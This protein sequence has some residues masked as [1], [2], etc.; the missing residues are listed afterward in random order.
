MAVRYEI[1]HTGHKLS[2]LTQTTSLEFASVITNPT[3]TGLVVLN[4]SPLFITPNIGVAT[5]SA[6][7]NLLKSGGTLTGNL[8]FT[9]NT[10]DIGASGATRPRTGYFGTSLIVPTVIGS[11]TTAGNLI[12]RGNSADLTTGQVNITSSLEASSISVAALTTA[13]GLAVAKRLWTTDLTSTNLPTLGGTAL[14]TTI[15]KLNY[16][17]SVTGV[18]GTSTGKVVLDTAPTFVTSLT[19]PSILATANDGGALG[20]SGTAFS[21]LFLA[22]GGVINFNAGDVTLTHSSDTLTLGGTVTLALGTTNITMTGS[23]GITGSRLTK[24]WFTD[25]EVSN[26]IAGSIMGTSAKATNLVGGNSTTGLGSIGYQSNT[27][28]TTMLAPNT[29]A[30]LKFLSQTGTGTNGAAPTWHQLLMTELPPLANDTWL[31][32]L[33]Y[34]GGTSNL[35]KLSADNIMEF[36]NP[37][38][39]CAL[40]H[41]LNSGFNDIVDIP[42]DSTSADGTQHGVGISVDGVRILSVSAL[43]TGAG[44]VDTPRVSVAGIVNLKNYTV[45]TLPAGTRGDICYVTDALAPTFLATIVAGGAIVTPVFFDGTTWKGF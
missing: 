1:I 18:T 15:A 6:S 13:G 43:S 9:D 23:L 10:L 37:V 14:T 29:T 33:N 40:Y 27:D 38:K 8:L 44:S 31:T 20:A 16:L 42:V 34:A 30:T 41:V 26:A 25:L 5:G 35:F 12:L 4:D 28:T 22:S 24:G 36:A 7:L 32:A 45:G 39:I 17:T 11:V 2:K 19:T 3:G 21:D